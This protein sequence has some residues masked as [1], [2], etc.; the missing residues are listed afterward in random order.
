V[1]RVKIKSSGNTADYADPATDPPQQVGGAGSATIK[2]SSAANAMTAETII[3]SV[4]GPTVD[5][6]E[7]GRKFMEIGHVHQARFDAKH[8]LYNDT[9]P[10]KRRRSNLDGSG[11][12]N[13]GGTYVFT[14]AGVTGDDQYT[15]VTDGSRVPDADTNMNEAFDSQTWSTEDQ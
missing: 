15:E 5:G 11:D 2:S 4:D 7:R 1:V 6:G 12:I 14:G 3:E 13:A 8:G 10:A 9:T